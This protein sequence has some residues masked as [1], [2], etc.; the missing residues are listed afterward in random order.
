M[1]LSDISE[2]LNVMVCERCNKTRY[3]NIY[4]IHYR[5]AQSHTLYHSV[6][7]TSLQMCQIN[8]EN[9][10]HGWELLL[11]CSPPSC[12]GHVQTFSHE[13]ETLKH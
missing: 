8:V 1:D 10:N 13:Y 2:L 12:E 3:V 11:P 5:H 4:C 7:Q 9:D 6:T